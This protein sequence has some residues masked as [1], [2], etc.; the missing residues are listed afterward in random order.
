MRK[1][2]GSIAKPAEA[3][4][5]TSVQLNNLKAMATPQNWAE[6][7]ALAEKFSSRFATLYK[8]RQFDYIHP[9]NL[10]AQTPSHFKRAY[11]VNISYTD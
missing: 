3:M 10:Q 2:T 5:S 4:V 11:P 7:E 1:I 8:L 6:Y 9:V